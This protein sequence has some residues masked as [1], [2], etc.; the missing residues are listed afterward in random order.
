VDNL[1]IGWNSKILNSYESLVENAAVKE[2][3]GI[4]KRR[5]EGTSSNDIISSSA[6]VGSPNLC[7]SVEGQ[8]NSKES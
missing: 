8:V 4:T 6:G 5:R 7:G 1:C 3:L 2:S